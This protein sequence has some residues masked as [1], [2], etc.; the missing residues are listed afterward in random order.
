MRFAS[1][2][3]GAET[4]PSLLLSLAPGYNLSELDVKEEYDVK[5]DRHVES[6]AMEDDPNLALGRD[7]ITERAVSEIHDIVTPELV[8][9][10]ESALFGGNQHAPVSRDLTL[11][12]E[13][14]FQD[15]RHNDVVSKSGSCGG[16]KVDFYILIGPL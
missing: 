3:L 4:L 8:L 11:S 16:N 2:L 10:G 14:Y 12:S 9:F 5:G 13:S 6:K 1:P 15:D 7:S